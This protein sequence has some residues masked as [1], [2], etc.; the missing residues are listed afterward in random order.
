MFPIKLS[1]SVFLR[2]KPGK[3]LP[4]FK[5]KTSNSE[6]N[7]EK[8]PKFDKQIVA[9]NYKMTFVGTL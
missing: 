7:C 5:L 3:Y 9:I 4:E 8:N 2:E 6:Q 1:L